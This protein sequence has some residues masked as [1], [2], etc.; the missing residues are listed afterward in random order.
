MSHVR[1]EHISRR[2]TIS[3]QQLR[4]EIFCPEQSPS[5]LKVRLQLAFLVD[6]SPSSA[7]GPSLG[8]HETLIEITCPSNS[9]ILSFSK[10]PADGISAALSR[11]V[12]NT[13]FPR[14]PRSPSRKLFL[15]RA[16]EVI[17]WFARHQFITRRGSGVTAR[18][19]SA[20]QRRRW[21]SVFF[22]NRLTRSRRACPRHLPLSYNDYG[23]RWQKRQRSLLASRAC[24]CEPNDFITAPSYVGS[25]DGRSEF[26][27]SPERAASDPACRAATLT[28]ACC[29]GLRASR[30]CEMLYHNKPVDF[31]PQERI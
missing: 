17:K 6:C 28:P 23:N 25:L 19:E 3:A 24:Q 26:H 13:R 7:I 8:A 2:C 18:E 12:A 22:I 10:I 16:D 30:G 14:R 20:S 11:F 31:S 27:H 9:R 5:G 21:W 4:Q 15:V 29:A 1:M